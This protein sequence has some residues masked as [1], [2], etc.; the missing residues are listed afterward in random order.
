MK[1]KRG[2][3]SGFEIGEDLGY[4]LI[5]IIVLMV[6]VFFVAIIANGME[7]RYYKNT[8]GTNVMNVEER[9]F[10][11]ISHRDPDT[12][13][14]YNKLLDT[15]LFDSEQMST[16]MGIMNEFDPFGIRVTIDHDLESIEQGNFV[17]QFETINF[18]DRPDM[19]KSYPLVVYNNGVL[20]PLVVRIEFW[21]V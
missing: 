19:T 3:V 6:L 11:C 20:T 9:L 4:K 15:S 2:V 14:L 13:V 21:R 1:S 5:F 12:G 18:V 10:S 7:T 17:Y 16:C 8:Y